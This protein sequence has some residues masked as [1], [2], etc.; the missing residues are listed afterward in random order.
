MSI[1]I[2]RQPLLKFPR[3]RGQKALAKN[4][5][6]GRPT[7]RYL[8]PLLKTGIRLLIILLLLAV[9]WVVPVT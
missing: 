4:D 5:C 1:S 6:T 7:F 9:V 8:Y 2:I 3:L